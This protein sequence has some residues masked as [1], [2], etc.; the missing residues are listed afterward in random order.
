MI[1]SKKKEIKN[2]IIL[3]IKED[4]KINLELEINNTMPNI[5]KTMGKLLYSMHS[6]QL[7][8]VFVDM[9]VEYGIKNADHKHI[10]EE[11]ITYWLKYQNATDSNKAYISPTKVFNQ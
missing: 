2:Q 4:D 6:G 3:S 7:Q 10:I 11:I 1:F 8:D 9:L 5:G